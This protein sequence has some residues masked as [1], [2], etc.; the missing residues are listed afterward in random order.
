MCLAQ[1]LINNKHSNDSCGYYLCCRCWRDYP[2]K[3]E[4]VSSNSDFFLLTPN[5]VLALH[6]KHGKL[7]PER[8]H[9]G[10]ACGSCLLTP[11][12]RVL[13]VLLQQI[14]GQSCREPTGFWKELLGSLLRL[15]GQRAHSVQAVSSCRP[16]PVCLSPSST[17]APTGGQVSYTVECE[18]H[19]PLLLSISRALGNSLQGLLTFFHKCESVLL[20]FYFSFRLYTN[21]RKS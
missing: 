7:R 9:T 12:D 19:F 14:P 4:C 1:S 21:R 13:L 11:G 8:W 5:Q 2:W 3:S 16:S 20:W 6:P 18:D 17:V 15:S 10:L